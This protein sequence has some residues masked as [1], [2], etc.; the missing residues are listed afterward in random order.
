MR[1]RR[2]KQRV[3]SRTKDRRLALLRQLAADVIR[4]GKITTTEAKAK[5]T[6]RFLNRIISLALKPSLATKQRLQKLLGSKL[7]VARLLK[8]V[9][10]GLKPRNGSYLRLSKLPPRRGDRSKMAQL[11]IIDAKDDK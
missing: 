5:E 1:H 4:H 8:Q 2:R 7:V 6:R 11:D 9:A 3:L 10:S